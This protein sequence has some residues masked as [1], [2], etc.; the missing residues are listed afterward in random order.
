M[1]LS[2][3]LLLAWLSRHRAA[4]VLAQ[5]IRVRRSTP[6]LPAALGLKGRIGETDGRAVQLVVLGD[7]L[8]AAVGVDQHADA[9]GGHLATRI[10]TRTSRPVEWTI[11]GRSGATAREV[12]ALVDDAVLGAADIVVVSVGVNDTKN[13]HSR[14][15]WRAQLSALLDR[16]IEASPQAAILFIPLAPLA[17][18]P[19]LPAPLK[20]VLGRR[21]D[22]F[23]AI[24]GELI[25]VRPRILLSDVAFEPS[26]RMFAADGFHPSS[27]L[28]GIFADGVVTALDRAGTHGV[29][30]AVEQEPPH[31]RASAGIFDDPSS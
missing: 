7:S 23:N 30:A 13:L 2:G 3:V 18:F 12:S 8:A 24:A 14:A 20:T 17:E 26:H 10:S 22:E 15:T 16:V 25:A 1:T 6:R 11:I 19:A 28:H 4:I 31:H 5:G 9:L 21:A 29:L 27:A